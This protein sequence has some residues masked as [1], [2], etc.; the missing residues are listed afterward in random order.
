[1]R[2][3]V[4]RHGVA[5]ADVRIAVGDRGASIAIDVGEAGSAAAVEAFALDGSG[6]AEPLPATLERI[7]PG[8]FSARVATGGKPFV[9]ARVRDA[10]GAL[11]GEALGQHDAADELAE[12]GP[13]ERALRDLAAGGGGLYDPDPARALRTGGPRGRELVPIW[14]W[15][16]LAAALLV[17]ADLW[18]RRVGKARAISSAAQPAAA[19]SSAIRAE[20]A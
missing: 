17:V 15:V 8:R 3:A 9:L 13:D 1:V 16:L 12:I 4:R 14:P 19:P 6:K 5:A 2:F 18:L 20:A 10:S 11:L 7:G